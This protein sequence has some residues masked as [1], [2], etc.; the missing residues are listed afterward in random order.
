MTCSVSSPSSS[1]TTSRIRL[2]GDALRSPKQS[3]PHFPLRRQKMFSQT[4]PT[5]VTP[6]DDGEETDS[7]CVCVCVCVFVCVCV[8]A[9]GVTTGYN[10]L[11]ANIS[12]IPGLSPL[13]SFPPDENAPGRRNAV[14]DTDSDYV[15]LSKQGGQKGLLR[16]EPTVAAKPNAYTP[17]SWNF[18]PSENKSNL[19]LNN[20]VEKKI[21]EVF[22]PLEPPF[23]SD[24]LTAWERTGTSN[25]RR[26]DKN[27]NGHYNQQE[28]LLTPNQNLEFSKFRRMVHDKKPAPTDMS[29]LLSFGYADEDK[30]TSHTDMSN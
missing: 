21:P 29:K 8:W 2:H 7:V 1:C 12:Q 24:S 19:S 9:T 23:G 28:N 6:H 5:P 20:T 11:T 4:P 14:R 18:Y 26:T 15:K 27:N 3:P 16:H 17:P 25:T 30:P 22:Q 13:A 10:P